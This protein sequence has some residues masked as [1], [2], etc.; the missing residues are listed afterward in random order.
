MNTNDKSTHADK[1]L[2]YKAYLDQR[3]ALIDIEVDASNRLDR[4]IITLSGGALGLSLTFI[5]KIA[6]NP[7]QST[8]WLLGL[9]WFS[10]LATLLISL[11]SHLT[12]QSAMRRQRD[13]LALEL[14]DDTLPEDAKKNSMS[15]ITNGLNI[16][17]MVFFSLGVVF[18]CTFTLLNLPKK[19]CKNEGHKDTGPQIARQVDNG[20]SCPKIS[21]TPAQTNKE[22]EV[23]MSNLD[24][25][26]TRVVQPT[27][28]DKKAGVVAP[29]NARPAPQP[30]PTQSPSGPTKEK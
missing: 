22:G 13:I 6:P 3:Q 30:K 10:L 5:E 24:A 25:K 9:S 18:L 27:G 19:E 17:A 2:K 20:G 11:T 4:G 16:L 12:S 23:T 1:Q 8:I 14:D 21:K 26:K 15:G 28:I 29:K 7:S